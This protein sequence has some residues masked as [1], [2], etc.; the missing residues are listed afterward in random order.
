MKKITLLLC[1]FAFTAFGQNPLTLQEYVDAGL[2]NEATVVQRAEDHVPSIQTRGANVTVFTDRVD[3]LNNC[4]N[5]DLLTLEDFANGPAA[6]LTC[7]GSI[8]SVGDVCYPAGEIQEGIEF[9]TSG[10]DVG[11]IMIAVTP[12]DGFTLDNAVGSNTFLDFTI[13]NFSTPDPVTS[14]GFDLYSVTGGSNVD[15]RVIGE[16]GL[17]D[18]VTAD[19]TTTGP[20]FVGLIAAEPIV[21][22]EIEDLTGAN[23]E[24]VAQ[25]LFGSCD[26]LPF[27]DDPETAINLIVGE[28]FE[29]NPR[30]ADNT[31][32][33]DTA[34]DDPSCGSYAGGDLWYRVTVPDSG[35]VTVESQTDDDSIT[36]T[37][38]SIYEGEIGALVEVVCNDDGGPG[39][40][41]LAEVEGRTPGEV[42]FVRIWEW[43][44]G[45]V[46]TFQISAYDTPP[47]VN[48]DP[49]G[50]IPLMVGSVFT[51]FPVTASNV[52]ATDTMID[53]PSCGNY[54]GADVWFTVV[55][56]STGQLNVETDTAGGIT[57]TGMS[58]YTGEIGA[59]VE[60]NCNDDD[61]NGLFS[62]NAVDDPALAGMTL[63]VRVWEWGGGGFGPFQVAAYSDCAVDAVS[64]EITDTGETETTICAGDAFPDP[65]D[66]TVVGDGIGTNNGWVVTD[67]ATNDI[68]ALPAGPP[69]DFNDQPVGV[70]GIWYIRYEDGLTGLE[71]GMNVS[72]LSGCFDLSNPILVTRVDEGNPCPPENDEAM[73][74]TPLTVGMV[75]ADFAVIGS[76]LNATDSVD[77][78]P[79]CAAFNGSDVWYIVEVPATGNVTVETDTDDGSV[80]DTGL[81]IFEGDLGSLIEVQCNDDGGNGLYS[82]ISLTGRTPGEVLYARVW[83]FGGDTEG[84]FQISAYDNT[85]DCVAPI[86]LGTLNITETSADLTWEDGGNVVNP[87]ESYTVEWGETGFALGTGTIVTGITDTMLPLTGLDIG[88]SYDFYVSTSCS[89]DFESEVSG[90]FTFITLFEQAP[91]GE[92]E[93]TL[94]MLDSFGDGWNGAL[95]SVFRNGQIVLDSVTLDDD[96]ANDGFTGLLPFEVIPGDDITTALIDDGGFPAEIS[97]DIISSNGVS[98]IGSGDAE[99]DITSG[100]VIATTCSLSVDEN[101][102][103]DFSFFPNPAQDVINLNTRATIDNVAIFNLLGQKV[104]EQKVD[105]VS[106]YQLGVSTLAKGTYLMQVISDGK[107]GVYRVIKM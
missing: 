91:P 102:L 87:T 64:I 96:P 43:N 29:D 80:G 106:T 12:G 42:L 7:S 68:L 55:V 82:L 78:A 14:V 40:F 16:T 77:T 17:I 53:D 56:P 94:Q 44:G 85:P 27:N 103:E 10:A 35:M 18:T 73:T 69:F 98:V 97:Y 95:L 30:I 33:T 3:Y 24:I 65:I 2:H 9:T 52:S 61:G 71:V 4:M 8:S 50:A 26:P 47:P 76:N 104:L 66:V 63:F 86:N 105:G 57:D 84:T 100:T 51:D 49:E 36:D 37:A 6:F 101:S 74:A 58:L 89:N 13:I 67:N 38:L 46:G 60:L 34:I 23:A 99:N 25:V 81:S 75:F 45:S 39:L 32:A 28:V 92:C 21:S 41:S 54:G 48:D 1:F 31:E 5:G 79:S 83:E 19:V 11:N 59:L 62:L 70:C 20:T 107:I 22:L 93:Y 72:D 15:V 90:P 88:T